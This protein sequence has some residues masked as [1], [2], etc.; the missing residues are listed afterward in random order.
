MKAKSKLIALFLVVLMLSAMSLPALAWNCVRSG[1]PSTS[2]TWKWKT[3]G[4][5]RDACELTSGCTCLY[6]EQ[7]YVPKCNKCG[8]HDYYSQNGR[9]QYTTD[10]SNPACSA[11]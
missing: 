6:V 2:C 5:G 3:I 4:S 11:Y 7:V 9:K 1:C 10:H 8:E